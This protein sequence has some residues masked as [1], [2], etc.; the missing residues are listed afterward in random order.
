M[1]D[2]PTIFDR[3]GLFLEPVDKSILDAPTLARLDVVRAA[4]LDLKAAEAKETAALDEVKASLAAQ[5]RAE[6]YLKQNFPQPE[7]YDLWVETFGNA[8][9]KEK[10]R[11]ARAVSAGKAN[12][13]GNSR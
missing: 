3:K 10:H 13:A 5:E 9:E 8:D 11:R 12:P 2:L 1:S 7:F 6:Q 4:Y